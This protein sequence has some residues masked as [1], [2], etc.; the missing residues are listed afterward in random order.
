[1]RL[2]TSNLIYFLPSRCT[3]IAVN[4][5]NIFRINILLLLKLGTTNLFCP[6]AGQALPFPIDEKEAKIFVQIKL[7][8]H[9]LTDLSDPQA[10][11]TQ[12]RF[13]LSLAG[14]LFE[15]PTRRSYVILSLFDR[16]LYIEIININP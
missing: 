15:R 16:D 1:M 13:R 2:R 4:L 7:F 5:R 3:S 8:P 9:I 12:D 11:G 14:S 6:H 10:S